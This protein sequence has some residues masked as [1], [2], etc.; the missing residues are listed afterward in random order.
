MILN[1]VTNA[2]RHTATGTVTLGVRYDPSRVALTVRDTG[3]GIAA[4]DLEHIFDRFYRVEKS[5]SRDHGGVGLGLAIAR[6]LTELQGGTISVESTIGVG[7]V[8]SVW[9]PAAEPHAV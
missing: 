1:I 6:M 4:G 5:R 9:L 3:E 8:F 7:S 2:V